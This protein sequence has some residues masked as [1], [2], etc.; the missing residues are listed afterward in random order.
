MMTYLLQFMFLAHTR[1][2][3]F[4]NTSSSGGLGPARPSTLRPP[5]M[6]SDSGSIF[7]NL[8]DFLPFGLLNISNVPIIFLAL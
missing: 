4:N 8:F 5:G 2:T 6:E 7:D 1:S 3:S